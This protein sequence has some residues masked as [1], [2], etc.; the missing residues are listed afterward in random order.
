MNFS[1]L[2][3]FSSWACLRHSFRPQQLQQLADVIDTGYGGEIYA[4]RRSVH[5]RL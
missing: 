3:E 5:N 1:I 4:A 2:L